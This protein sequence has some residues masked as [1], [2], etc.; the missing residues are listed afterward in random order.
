MPFI[1]Y[2]PGKITPGKSDAMVSQLD[3][4]YSF[5]KM[6]NLNLQENDGP[7][8]FEML[9][10]LL[11][12]SDKGREWIVEHNGTWSIIKGDWKYIYPSNRPAYNKSTNT[13]LGNNPEPQ[14]YNLSSDLGEK[15]NLATQYPDKVKELEELLQKIIDDGRT[16]E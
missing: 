6:N 15:K 8:S 1:F 12:K 16:R 7:D 9:D 5:A 13:E 2:W 4:L 11:G 10:V 14:L 3:F